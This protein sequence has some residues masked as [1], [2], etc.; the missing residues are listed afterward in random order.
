MDPQRST[1]PGVAPHPIVLAAIG[2]DD[3]AQT[4]T[5][6]AVQAARLW[7]DGELHLAH[8]IDMLPV[9]QATVA[10]PSDWTY[11]GIDDLRRQSDDYLSRFTR[12]AGEALGRRVTGHLLAGTPAAELMRLANELRASLLVVGTRDVG[13]LTRLLMGST[14]QTLLRHAPCSVLVAR[15]PQYADER[16][17]DES[18]VCPDCLQ[19]EATSCGA[20]LRCPRHALAYGR[21]HGAFGAEGRAAP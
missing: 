5:A 14:A 4:V 10:C 12:P 11:P 13:S 8:V 6:M 3:T 7:P 2:N 18:D 20:T 19:A 9:V 17:S 15:A 1:R 16:P 21:T